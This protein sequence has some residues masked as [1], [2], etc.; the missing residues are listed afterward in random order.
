M[1]DALSGFAFDPVAG[2]RPN[3]A[4]GELAPIDPS[5]PLLFVDSGV[6]VGERNPTG[7]VTATRAITLVRPHAKGQAP[8]ALKFEVRYP[9]GRLGWREVA[10]WQELH[11]TA[12]GKRP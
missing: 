9:A 8:P 3:A 11:E 6:S 4:T 2:A 5:L 10:N 7:G 12:T 1:V